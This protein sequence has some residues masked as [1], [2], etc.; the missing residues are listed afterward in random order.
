MIQQGSPSSPKFTWRF[1]YSDKVF[2]LL[3][4]LQDDG[5]PIRRSQHCGGSV[6]SDRIDS[7][8]CL[9]LL[10]S[11]QTAGQEDRTPGCCRLTRWCFDG[12]TATETTK[13]VEKTDSSSMAALEGQGHGQEDTSWFPFVNQRWSPNDRNSIRFY[14]VSS[15]GSH[16][17]PSAVNSPF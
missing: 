11:M 12:L 9:R 16:A 10:A 17:E 6:S 3:L 14:V 4:R 5:A 1:E 8:V 13:E 2:L 7:R 15:R